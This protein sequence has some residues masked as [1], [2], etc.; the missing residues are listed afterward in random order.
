MMILVACNIEQIDIGLNNGIDI[1]MN[2]NM[3]GSEMSYCLIV[4]F[5]C[6]C[7]FFFFCL[8]IMMI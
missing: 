6:S 2:T 7:F 5:S 8:D 4:F 1:S 3:G